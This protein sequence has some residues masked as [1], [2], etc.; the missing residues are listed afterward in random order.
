MRPVWTLV[1]IGAVVA[2]LAAKATELSGASFSATTSNPSN[3]FQA[4]TSFE[5]I[6]LA[7]GTY[8]GNGVDNRAISGLGFQPDVVIVK[9]NANQVAVIRT[10]TMTGDAS[11]PMSGATGLVAD[12]IQALQADGFQVGANSAVNAN[13]TAYYWIALKAAAA[14]LRVGTYTGNGTSQ[15]VGGLGFS[16]E[17]VATL[18]AGANQA[19]MRFQGMT[20]AF[21]FDSTNP[22]G[23]TTTGITS[24]DANGFSVGADAQANANGTTYHYLAFN[25]VAGRID[26]GSYTGNNTDNRNVTGVG[27][28]P[29]YAL[30]RANDTGTGRLGVHRPSSLGGDSSLR[31]NNTANAANQIQALQADGFQLG[32]NSDVNANGVTYHHLAIKSG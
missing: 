15:S 2:L 10:S 28:Q 12:R 27:F 14:E 22:A 29:G 20:R 16:P 6:R 8:S 17:Y 30:I 11:K 23:G 24:L 7:S 3:G 18:S 21:R 31:F 4:A 26:T 32:N 9:G 25:E 1:L 5:K 13:G 19:I